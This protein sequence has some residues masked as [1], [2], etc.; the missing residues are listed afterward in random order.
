ML[1]RERS[2]G[3]VDGG[4]KAMPVRPVESTRFITSLWDFKGPLQFV[5]LGNEAVDRGK[6]DLK[7]D[8][9]TD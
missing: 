8:A 9:P 2:Q 7:C 6:R 3:H 4:S 5:K 1:Q